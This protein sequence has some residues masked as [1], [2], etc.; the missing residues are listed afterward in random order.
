[1]THMLSDVQALSSAML[2]SYGPAG[3]H[4]HGDL[5]IPEDTGLEKGLLVLLL[6]LIHPRT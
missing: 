1:M 2:R 3:H 6:L 5:E 4:Q